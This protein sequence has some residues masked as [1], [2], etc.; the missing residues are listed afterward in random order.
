MKN[1]LSSFIFVSGCVHVRDLKHL[2]SVF[3]RSILN[4][5]DTLGV[6]PFEFFLGCSTGCSTG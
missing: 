1:F 3:L 2:T 4:F 6:S 5:Y